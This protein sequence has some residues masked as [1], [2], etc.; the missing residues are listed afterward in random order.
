MANIAVV[1]AT[2]EQRRLIKLHGCSFINS[3]L[4]LKNKLYVK[5]IT[6]I[7]YFVNKIYGFHA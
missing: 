5:Y 1:K 3:P 2:P 7:C 4:Y 6:A